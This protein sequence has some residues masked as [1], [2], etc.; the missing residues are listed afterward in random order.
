MTSFNGGAVQVKPALLQPIR[1]PIKVAKLLYTPTAFVLRAPIYLIFGILCTGLV[2]SVFAKKDLLVSAP[3]V[4]KKDSFTIQATGSGEIVE[5][6]AKENSFVNFGEKL[7]VIREQLRPFDNAQRDAVQQHVREL[8]KEKGKL[9]FEYSSKIAQLEYDIKNYSTNREAK[10]KELEGRIGI[11]E[12]QLSTAR[13]SIRSAQGGL[14]IATRQYDTINKL[15]ASHDATISQRDNALSSLNMAQ[16]SVFDARASES[17]TQIQLETARSELDKFKNLLELKKI[18]DELAHSKG[19]QER[20]LG[21][22][23]EQINALAERLNKAESSDGATTVYHDDLVEYI[24]PFDGLVTKVQA[25]SGQMIA[26]GSP[27]L[28]LVRESAALEGNAYVDNK[29]IGHLKREQEVKIK[30]FAYPYQEYGIATGLISDIA[31]TPSGLPGKESKYVVTIVLREETVRK[32]NGP[33][34]SLKIGLEGIA[35]IKTGEQRF[36]EILF[37]PISRFFTQEEEST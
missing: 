22:L 18:E 37:A 19:Q 32:A 34:R 14:A 12:K 7:A 27:L 29:D 8:E 33:A 23:N 2:Y 24:T 5:V 4:L 35:E 1:H 3:L 15:F 17:E 20:E 11:L 21:K 13:N 25:A 36:I 26:P 10:S 9:E 30:Y 28:T 6:R 16:K 31:T